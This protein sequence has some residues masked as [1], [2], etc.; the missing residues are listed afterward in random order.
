[1]NHLS[2]SCGDVRQTQ[3]TLVFKNVILFKFITERNIFL[4]YL[5]NRRLMH[6][7]NNLDLRNR[8]QTKQAQ[9]YFRDSNNC[10]IYSTTCNPVG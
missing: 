10:I 5:S 2:R 1:M 3:K 6:K 8:A 4:F 9:K 7:L